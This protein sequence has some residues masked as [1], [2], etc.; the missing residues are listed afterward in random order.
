MA[1]KRKKVDYKASHSSLYRAGRKIEEVRAGKAAFLAVDGKGSPGGETYQEAMKQL[2]TLAYSAKFG[3]KAE[4][5]IDFTVPPV[6]CLWFDDPAKKSMEEWRWR[7]L[8]RIPDAV[9]GKHLASIRR[10]IKSKKGI[11]TSAVKRIAR[12][13]GRALQ[14]LHVGPYD[15][16]GSAYS[17]IMEEAES[18]RLSCVGPGHEIYLNDPRR[19]APS[20]LKTI[21][22]MPVKKAAAR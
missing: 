18:R 14:V 17:G 11:D 2:F 20:R 4:G 21:V 7:I 12:T 19:A 5:V 9:T 3:L 16:V 15:T 8:L 22:R 6:E 10:M 1:K 13:E